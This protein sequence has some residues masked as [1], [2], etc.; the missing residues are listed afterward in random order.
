[1]EISGLP[2]HPLVVHAVVVF[3]PLSGLTALLYAAVPRWR[4]ALRWPL[5]AM[6]AIAVVTALLA[7]ASGE[8]LLE[9]R[10]G[11]ES[12]PGVE[13]HGEAGEM[14]RNI[15]VGFGLVTFLGAW[16]LGFASPLGER[17]EASS[18][19]AVG[20]VLRALMVVASL[21]VLY[22]AFQAGDTGARAVWG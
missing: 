5:V 21:A 19:G 9:S 1:M 3:A 13:E 12:L 4:W 6:T 22:A 17:R 2:L 16:R 10:E 18:D 11:L 20:L 14:L 8:S 15:L 7:A